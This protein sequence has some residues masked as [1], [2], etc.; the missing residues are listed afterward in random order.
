MTATRTRWIVL[1]AAVSAVVGLCVPA[2]AMAS[3]AGRMP[4]LLV[5]GAGLTVS[6][7]LVPVRA[8]Q[9]HLHA[10]GVDP[11][12]VDGRFG[13]R[14]EAAVRRFQSAHGIAV[15]GI[16]GPR[17][18]RRLPHLNTTA[19]TPPRTATPPPT[20]TAPRYAPA[21]AKRPRESGRGSGGLDPV[22]MGVVIALAAGALALLAAGGLKWCRRRARR[23]VAA[24]QLVPAF[25]GWPALPPTG[26]P[27]RWPQPPLATQATS[28]AR[29]EPI[30]R[31]G[32]ASP[33]APTLAGPPGP[34]PQ[35]PARGPQGHPAAAPAAGG[36][37]GPAPAAPAAA[38]PQAPPAPRSVRA[39]GYV[40]V[41]PDRPLDAAAAAQAQAIEAACAA[42][43]WTFVAGVR[44]PEPANGTGLQRPG[45]THAL[46]RLTR[47]EA[48]CLMVTELA[49]L[50][51][52]AVELGELL[53]R[54]GRARVRLV[55]LDLEIDTAT[56]SGRL[57]A[58]ALTTASRME[59][60]QTPHGRN[61][62]TPSPTP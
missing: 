21:A 20:G 58:R 13:P 11:G 3:G 17:T 7:G 23:P 51:R 8:L 60:D 56:D 27:E 53:G 15:D 35:T 45:L 28:A 54:L 38:T 2:Q 41:P 46:E 50:T 43:G 1:L 57:A 6:T 10:S 49:R 37:Q 48:D 47:D 33:G 30:P 19:P 25:T 52:S 39:L 29:A 55:V 9:R 61:P 62:R 34:P 16:V 44:E 14:T 36:F 26:T 59:R 18:A 42:R 5:R 12:P 4:V 31:N 24:G 32:S 22:K 40:S